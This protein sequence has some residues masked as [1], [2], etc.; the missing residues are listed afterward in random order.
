MQAHDKPKPLNLQAARTLDWI[1]FIS[2]QDEQGGHELLDLN[3]HQIITRRIVMVVP[4]TS[5]SIANVKNMAERDD[6][7]RLKFTWS[8]GV[9]KLDK[10]DFSEN[11]KLP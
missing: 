3:T 9:D 11:D 1:Y 2:F 10:C 8:A 4:M 5:R 6:K 7:K